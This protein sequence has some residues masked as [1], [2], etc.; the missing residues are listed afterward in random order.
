MQLRLSDFK[1]RSFE[2]PHP[3]RATPLYVGY[4]IAS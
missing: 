3:T 1:Q 2:L 4:I